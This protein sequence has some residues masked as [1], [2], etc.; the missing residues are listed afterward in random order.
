MS[1]TPASRTLTEHDIP[2]LCDLMRQEPPGYLR[3]FFP[4]SGDEDFLASVRDAKRD[5]YIA[6]SL[7]DELAGFAMLRG[8]DAGYER[9]SFGV[10][11]SSGQAGR[12]LARFGLDRALET[13]HRIGASEVMLKVA[14]GN[15]RARSIYDA[16][17]FRL[18][19]QCERTGHD[20][21]IRKGTP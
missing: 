6:L 3:D 9:P 11:V 15:A 18:S 4:F 10:Y 14:P 21:M 13:A 8:M 12:G 19:G 16:A 2:A 1:G 5:V 7:G 20:V 17:G